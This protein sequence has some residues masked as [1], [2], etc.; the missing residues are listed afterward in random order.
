MGYL[1]DLNQFQAVAPLLPEGNKMTI[2]APDG[3]VF[4]H[5]SFNVNSGETVQ[6]VQPSANARVLNRI[7]SS[8]VSTINGLWKRMENFILP[9]RED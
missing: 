2:T 4:S 1:R 9:L 7:T 5:G 3:S 8:S 6:F